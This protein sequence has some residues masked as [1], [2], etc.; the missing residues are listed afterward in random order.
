MQDCIEKYISN[1]SV[2]DYIEEYIEFLDH[3]FLHSHSVLRNLSEDFLFKFKNKFSLQK[4]VFSHPEIF[5]EE[6]IL[7]HI[8]LFDSV[9]LDGRTL[10]FK[11]KF[12]EETVER[13][14][15]A[16]VANSIY[17]GIFKNFTK[18]LFEKYKSNLT[19]QKLI[20]WVKVAA[21]CVDL[22]EEFVKKHF[23]KGEWKEFVAHPNISQ[24][25]IID[26]FYD[27]EIKLMVH[28]IK[29]KDM[30]KVLAYG[31]EKNLFSTNE[32]GRSPYLQAKMTSDVKDYKE[33]LKKRF[34]SVE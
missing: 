3:E 10:E 17:S 2:Q 30:S 25:F 16:N 23:S 28:N 6:G 21:Y 32:Y 5:S 14:G 26:N 22:D 4:I 18:R 9:P 7:N 27:Y 11:I 29:N 12:I 8:H 33:K 19:H 13:D 31:I 20:D 1:D 15:E 24:E 34:T